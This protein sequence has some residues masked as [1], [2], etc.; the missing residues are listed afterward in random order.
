MRVALLLPV[1]FLLG[2]VGGVRPLGAQGTPEELL[3]RAVAMSNATEPERAVELLRQL[4]NALPPAAAPAVRREADLRLA[5][6]SWSLGLLD[7]AAVHF[8]AVVQQ[9]AFLRLDPDDYNPELVTAFDAARRTV[10]A[11]GVRPSLDTLIDARTGRWQ[12]A[13]A[14]SQPGQVRLRLAPAGGSGGGP[15]TRP[16][17]L[18]VESS[19]IASF[20]VAGADSDRLAPGTYRLLVEYSGPAGT[21][22]RSGVSFE[23]APATPDSMAHEPPPPDSLFRLEFRWGPRSRRPLL[24]GVGV[25]VGAVAIPLLL[26]HSQ[27]RTWGTESRALFVGATVSI[28]GVAAHFLGRPKQ[29]LPE[30]I[31]Y[32][33]ALR[34][35][36]EERN[37]SIAAV[38]AA[39]RSTPLLRVH[40]VPEP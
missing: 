6:T 7:S 10:V 39:R 38:N 2:L 26:G 5:L 40:V 13:V 18:A 31:E 28:A 32:N 29:L 34:S 9:D 33:R 30:N 27:L 35:A 1:T 11:V 23:V 25:G 21:A 15:E 36:W 17:V 3:A 12:V 8:Q 24:R 4:L 14:V 20:A 22:A 16:V 19:A 37:S